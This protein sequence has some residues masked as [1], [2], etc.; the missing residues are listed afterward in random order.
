MRL[1]TIVVDSDADIRRLLTA[2]IGRRGH[3]VSALTE[4][5]FCPIYSEAGGTCGRKHPCADLMVLD[6]RAPGM[7]GLQLLRLQRGGRCPMQA[8]NK[9]I[10]LTSWCDGE[11]EEIEAMG[12]KILKKPFRLAEFSDWIESRQKSIPPGRR[13]EVPESLKASAG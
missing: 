3:Q 12:C 11:K 5:S 7:P 9:A 13:L 1:R 6:Q 8:E 2:Y 4:P 10:M